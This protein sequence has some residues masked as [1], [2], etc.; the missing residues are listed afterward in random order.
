MWTNMFGEKIVKN[1]ITFSFCE[2]EMQKITIHSKT[3]TEI[4]VENNC[5]TPPTNHH[6]YSIHNEHKLRSAGWKHH[7]QY[8]RQDNLKAALI[9]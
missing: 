2:N 4:S 3:A 8:M 9:S 7:I 5:N 6:L 1:Y